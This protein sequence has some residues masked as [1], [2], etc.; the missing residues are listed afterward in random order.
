M[1]APLLYVTGTNTGV[2]KTT[3]ACLLL[4]RARERNLR[5]A[6][7]KPFSTGGREDAERLRALQTAGLKLDEVNPVHFAEP[8]APYVAAAK[9]KQTVT[10]AQTIVSIQK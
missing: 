5:V 7:M 4:R 9:Q 3:L 6:A 2:G 8:V 1:T 10:L